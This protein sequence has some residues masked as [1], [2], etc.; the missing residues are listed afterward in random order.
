MADR[1]KNLKHDSVGAWAKRLYFAS[2]AV[3]D[4]VLRPYDLGSTQWYVLYQLANEG[5]TMQRDL[6]RMLQIERA[7]LSGVVATL[8]RKGLVDQAPDSDDQ[9]QRMLRITRAGRKLWKELPDPIE[10]ILTAAFDGADPAELAIARRVLQVATQRL[11]Q[12]IL[13]GDQA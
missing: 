5:P 10:L 8:V 13:K 6:V 11:N 12:H 7:T 4:S 1:Q 9:R 3:M 2:R